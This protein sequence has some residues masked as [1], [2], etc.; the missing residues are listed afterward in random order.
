VPSRAPFSPFWS[1]PVVELRAAAAIRGEHLVA[2]GIV[3]DAALQAAAVHQGDRYR[4]LWK[5][6]QVI[7]RAVE[8]IDDPLKVVSAV[9]TAFLGEDGMRGVGPANRLD[10]R[11]FG[12]AID[13]ADIV[14]CLLFRHRKAVEAAEGA[15]DHVTGLACCAYGDVGGGVHG[16]RGYGKCRLPER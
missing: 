7:G 8:W 14:V 10:D 2:Q 9:L 1:V 3:D 11:L 15:H 16:A 12:V 4:E 6:M 5:T 13:L